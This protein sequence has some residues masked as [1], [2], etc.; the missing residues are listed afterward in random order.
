M[1]KTKITFNVAYY[2]IWLLEHQCALFVANV[3][4][5]DVGNGSL[6][7]VDAF[8]AKIK[9]SYLGVWYFNPKQI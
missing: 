9:E 3:L 7:S 4:P 5:R 6:I 8:R 2:R 1:S